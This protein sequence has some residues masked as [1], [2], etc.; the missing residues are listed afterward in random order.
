MDEAD[1]F[2]VES[3]DVAMQA[4]KDGVARIEMTWD[5]AYEIAKRDIKYS[6]DLTQ[7]LTELGFIEPAP[8]E[9]LQEALNWAVEQVA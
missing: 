3:A 6:R 8:Q 1:V 7:K 9:M 4:I 5:E 2:P